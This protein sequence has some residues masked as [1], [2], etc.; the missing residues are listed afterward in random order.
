MWMYLMVSIC[1]CGCLIVC[2][3]G[4]SYCIPPTYMTKWEKQFKKEK[5]VSYCYYYTN[6]CNKIRKLFKKEKGENMSP[7]KTPPAAASDEYKKFKNEK[8]CLLLLSSFHQLVPCKHGK[9]GK[10]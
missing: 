10:N 2:V 4:A 6:I 3:E 9:H 7:I 1:E 8:R 5:G